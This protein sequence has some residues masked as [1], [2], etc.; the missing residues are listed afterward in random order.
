VAPVEAVAVGRNP[1]SLAYHRYASDQVLV[2]CRGDRE[3][4][5]L[6]TVD[7][8][9]TVI[10]RLRDERLVDPV[11]CEIAETHGIETSLLTVC[12]FKGGKILNYR[13]S[14][15]HF[16]TN[17]GARFGMGKDGKDEF[18]CGGWLEFPAPPFAV[19][20]TNVN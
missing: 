5:W 6:K 11:Q 7:G 15:V 9:S 17:G 18:E 1:V 13:F 8:A 16:A 3:I 14:E 20:A 12:D 4:D 19:C 2:V 10:R